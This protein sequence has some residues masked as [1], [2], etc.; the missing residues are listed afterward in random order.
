MVMMLGEVDFGSVFAPN[1]DGTKGLKPS[2]EMPFP[3][4]TLVFFVVFVC[5]M[6]IIIMNLMV[7]KATNDIYLT[8]A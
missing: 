5:F 2:P 4:Y 8:N 3:P 6:S 1:L 7:I